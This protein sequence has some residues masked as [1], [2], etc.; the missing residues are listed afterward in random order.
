M[1][2]DYDHRAATAEADD[3]HVWLRP[4][5]QSLPGTVL[6]WGWNRSAWGARITYGV[7]HG[8]VDA[9][10]TSAWVAESQISTDQPA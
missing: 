9:G 5:D 2:T 10:V 7:P 8:Y 6:G 1:T 4:G 3:P